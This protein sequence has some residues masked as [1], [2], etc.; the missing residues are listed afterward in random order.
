MT[1]LAAFRN[2]MDEVRKEMEATGRAALEEEIT[3]FFQKWGD[4][5][6]GAIRWAQYTPSWN[7]GDACTFSVDYVY[8]FSRPDCEV[9]DVEGTEDIE[10]E[11]EGLNL[12]TYSKDWKKKTPNYP[13][14]ED[15][16]ALSSEIQSNPELMQI[17][18]GDHVRIT[19]TADNVEVE[20]Y[21]HD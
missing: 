5:G 21:E 3:A 15:F 18:Y 16:D 6:P 17:C 9:P 8:A 11:D 20:D 1:K 4:K 10:N 7:D 19:A 2:K 12:H 14:V 13:W